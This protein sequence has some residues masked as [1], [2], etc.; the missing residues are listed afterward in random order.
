M[1]HSLPKYIMLIVVQPIV[2]NIKHGFIKILNK[3]SVANISRKIWLKYFK[4]IIVGK[5]FSFAKFAAACG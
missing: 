5:M 1:L 4:D 2:L 3:K